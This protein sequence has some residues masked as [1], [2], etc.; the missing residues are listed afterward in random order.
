MSKL[1]SRVNFSRTMC[2]GVLTGWRAGHLAKPERF[3]MEAYGS[4][5]PSRRRIYLS[6]RF[7]LRGGVE[8]VGGMGT[9]PSRSTVSVYSYLLYDVDYHVDKR[10]F[11]WLQ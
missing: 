4:D 11:G 10:R 6:A 5:K 8:T 2:R 3:G 9:N 7:R 1:M